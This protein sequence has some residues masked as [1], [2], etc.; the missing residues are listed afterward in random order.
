[1][2]HPVTIKIPESAPHDHAGEERTLHIEEDESILEVARR[3]GL[4]LPA[5]CQQGWCT[6]CA[7]RLTQGSA[8]NTRATRY[9]PEDEDAGFILTCTATPRTPLTLTTHQ[10]RALLE[11][12][13]KHDLPP[14]KAKLDEP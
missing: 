7:A 13:A 3:E 5:D 14:G 10:Q 6:T 9:Y 12:R 11:E 8:D 2:K 1:M 4:W